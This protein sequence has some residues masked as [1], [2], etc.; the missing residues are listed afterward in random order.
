M[1]AM[2]RITF[3]C[4]SKVTGNDKCKLLGIGK[5]L[6]PRCLKNV[7]VDNL[8]VTYRANKKTWMT[9]QISTEWLELGTLPR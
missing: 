7:N 5:C 1:K 6:R 4:C 9:F 8:P 3:L 2:E